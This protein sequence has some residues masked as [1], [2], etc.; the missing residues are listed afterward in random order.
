MGPVLSSNLLTFSFPKDRQ[1]SWFFRWNIQVKNI[2]KLKIYKPSEGRP[3]KFIWRPNIAFR[4]CFLFL[5]FCFFSAA[6]MA[7]GSS[8]VR[9]WIWAEVV[10]YTTAQERGILNPWCHS[11][12]SQ[13]IVF[14]L[15]RDTP[16]IKHQQKKWDKGP[17]WQRQGCS[18]LGGGVGHSDQCWKKPR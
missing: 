5:V 1:K 10:T 9:N 8:W 15:C 18:G 13:A 14:R 3:N 16:V 17:Y 2:D 6:S 7:Y 11:G 4:L 12:N